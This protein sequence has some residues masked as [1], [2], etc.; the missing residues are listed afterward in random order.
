MFDIKY[1]N[2]N[3]SDL[4]TYRTQ[5]MGIAT[6]MIIICHANTYH[7]ML[8]NF[9]VSIFSWGNF[10]VDIFLFLSGL[11]LYFSLRKNKLRTKD[12]FI[13]FYKRRF[14]R[15]IIPY[16]IIYLPY[17]IFFMFLGKYSLNDSL[18]CLTTLE[19][20]LF[21]RGAWFVSMILVLYLIAPFLYKALSNKHKW[22]I[23]LGI[24][25]ILFILCNTPIKNNYSNS[26][27]YNIQWA[28][29][30]VPCFILGITIGCS[31][32][33]GKQIIALQVLLFS[34]VSVV[35][36]MFIGVWNCGCLIVP[37]MLY[38]F[39]F[40]IK[41]MEETWIVKSF[42][43]LG[44]ISLESYLT[45]ITLKSIL[46]LFIPAYFTSPFLYGHYLDYTVV[47]VTGLF[48]AKI[49]YDVSQK[50]ITLLLTDTAR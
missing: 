18:L 36:S 35:T 15:I 50:I 33:D 26:I 49:I 6:L 5:L 41:L 29:N 24:I 8:P 48:L 44:T 16:W 45:N 7:V 47:I 39:I 22:L 9:L 40:L 11:G 17:C 2:A 19:Y 23:A 34:L 28:F 14:Y 21:H 42:K 31:C 43:F 10:G 25:I 1:L 3:L 38:I 37:V 13:F 27:L 30:R 12:D 20:W 32:K 46:V 4:S